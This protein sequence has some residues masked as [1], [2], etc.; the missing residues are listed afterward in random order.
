MIA[1]TY[2]DLKRGIDDYV[3]RLITLKNRLSQGR[4]WHMLANRFGAGILTLIPTDGDFN[5]HNCE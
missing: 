1:E 2:P 4:N 3:E 5:V